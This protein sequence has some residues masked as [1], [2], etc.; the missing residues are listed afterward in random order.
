MARFNWGVKGHPAPYPRD[1]LV[2]HILLTSPFLTWG[3]T[4]NPLKHVVEDK[5]YPVTHVMHFWTTE[6]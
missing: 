6:I 5:L 1:P 2:L 4:I 3:Y